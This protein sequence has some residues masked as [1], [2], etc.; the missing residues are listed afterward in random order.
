[1]TILVL[2]IIQM[3]DIPIAYI[4][5]FILLATSIISFYY[6][7]DKIKNP[8]AKKIENANKIT[9]NI[10]GRFEPIEGKNSSYQKFVLTTHL[11]KV[12][13]P[14]NYYNLVIRI[15]VSDDDNWNNFEQ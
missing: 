9:S 7:I 4:I 10:T 6:N 1:M 11:T 12:E 3:V 8:I 5:A 14:D 13:S 2:L 15:Y